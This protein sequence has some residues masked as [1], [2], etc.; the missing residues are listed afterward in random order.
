MFLKIFK[1]C[2]A[3]FQ[4]YKWKG[5]GKDFAHGKYVKNATYS[6]HIISTS[7]WYQKMDQYS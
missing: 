3:M 7:R 1:V 4:H 2:S 5:E 6:F